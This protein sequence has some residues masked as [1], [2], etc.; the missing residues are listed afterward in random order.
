MCAHA[1]QSAFNTQ[2]RFL[3]VVVGTRAYVYARMCV[4][5]MQV[6]RCV[7]GGGKVLIPVMAVGRA[8]ELLI[9]IEEAWRRSGLLGHVP[10][11]FAGEM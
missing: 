7:Q 11:Y 1:I 9:L 5:V 10:L 4:C 8:Q 6:L 2:S 3:H